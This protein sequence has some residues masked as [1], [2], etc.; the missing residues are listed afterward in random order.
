MPH[1]KTP[2]EPKKS[3]DH[4]HSHPHDHS[5]DHHHHMP[6]TGKIF[7]IGISLNLI[8]VAIE[9]FYGL[10][11]NS[12]ALMADAGHNLSDVAGLLLAW[13]GMTL[14]LK[15]PTKNQS[16]GFKKASIMAALGNSLFLLIAM[17]TLIW[18]AINRFRSP[19]ETQGMTMVVV[20]GIGILINGAT[21]LMFAKSRHHDLNLKA[22]Y[23]HMLT[24]AF[25]SLGVV[26][27][28]LLTLKFDMLWID[29]TISLIIAGIILVGSFQLFKQ[30]LRLAFDGVPDSIDF[31]EVKKY[32][33]TLPGV[34]E[35]YD[36]HIWALSSTEVALT[37]H[38]QMPQGTASDIFLKQLSENLKAKFKIQHTTIQ[39]IQDPSV[40]H[41]CN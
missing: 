26:V 37:A 12:L 33:K 23:F 38:L 31:N 41:Y 27:A 29:P 15:S 30:S 17:G 39:I 3:C 18:E 34:Q 10:K 36:L 13:A 2:H 16:Y 11:I 7:V 32:L 14:T 20:A 5:H 21:A 40:D 8:F 22:A 19:Q 6:P 28:G 24:D 25:V 1:H 35:V 4:D 9:F